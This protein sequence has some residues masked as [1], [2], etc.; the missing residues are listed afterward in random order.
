MGTRPTADGDAAGYMECI[1]GDGESIWLRTYGGP[2]SEVLWTA[3]KTT[4]GGFLLAGQTDSQGAGGLDFYIV[5]TDSEGH[6][7]WSR[8]FGGPATDRAFGIDLSPDGGALVAGFQG[9]DPETMN[10]RKVGNSGGGLS[11]AI[12]LM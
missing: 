9:E 5:R 3:E 10:M 4:D 12:D 8:A 1:N 2:K 7:L 6:E 11:E